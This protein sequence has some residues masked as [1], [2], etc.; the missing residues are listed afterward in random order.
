MKPAM[1][2]GVLLVSS[3]A[4]AQSPPSDVTPANASEAKYCEPQ[5]GE[6][7]HARDAAAA[8]V[9]GVAAQIAQSRVRHAVD[10]VRQ[11][12][13]RSRQSMGVAAYI[14]NR[15]S[16][17]WSAEELQQC[18]GEMRNLADAIESASKHAGTTEQAESF[19][20]AGEKMAKEC[21][22]EYRKKKEQ[23]A[24][25]AR[26]RMKAQDKRFMRPA[27]SARL[28]VEQGVRAGAHAGIRR[29]NSYARKS[30]VINLR[31]LY[32]NRVDIEMS[33]DTIADIKQV[34]RSLKTT[35]LSCND[36]AVR[37]IQSCNDSLGDEL[38][39][40]ASHPEDPANFKAPAACH[41]EDMEDMVALMLAGYG[42]N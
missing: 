36:R 4:F 16:P 32:D 23:E 31:T 12:L 21:V 20:A 39:A 6:L 27:L 9:K 19:I 1:L 29:E 5:I 22:D 41:T 34:L 25:A 3:A 33:D 30:G 14:Q 37:S 42:T 11:C 15:K 38:D 35:A 13:L 40:E 18:A 10:G 8:N 26:Q 2:A 17:S 28:C 7:G 24:V